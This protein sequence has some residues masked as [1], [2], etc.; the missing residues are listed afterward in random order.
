M[1]VS[2]IIYENYIGMF[3][4]IDMFNGMYTKMFLQTTRAYLKF[5]FRN[6]QDIGLSVLD[7]AIKQRRSRRSSIC[8]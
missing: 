8:L 7:W 4:V 3:N 1:F 5:V 2:E 6:T